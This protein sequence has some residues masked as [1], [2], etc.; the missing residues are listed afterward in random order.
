M[1]KSKDIIEAILRD[2]TSQKARPQKAL[3]PTFILVEERTMEDFLDFAFRFSEQLKY[4]NLTDTAEGTWQVFFSMFSTKEKI[5]KLIQDWG[6]TQEMEP[7]QA[8]FLSFLKLFEHLKNDINQITQ[9]H[10]DFFYKELLA[11]TVNEPIPDKVHL[12]FEPAKNSS[13]PKIEKDTPLNAGKDHSGN[14]RVYLTSR[15]LIVSHAS[16]ENIKTLFIDKN[17]NGE[18]WSAPYANS[19]DGQGTAFTDNKK[20]PPFGMSQKGLADANRNMVSAT[21]GFAIASPMLL[22]SEGTRNIKIDIA[23]QSRLPLLINQNLSNGFTILLSTHKG[24]VAPTTFQINLETESAIPALNQNAFNKITIQATL[25]P[26]MPAVSK[27]DD[28]LLKEGFSSD[29]PLVKILYDSAILPYDMLSK[30]VISTIDINT[31]VSGLKNVV[32]QNDTGVLDPGKPFNPF[33]SNPSPGSS[34]YIGHQEF[35]HKK[36]ENLQL[37]IDWHEVPQENLGTWYNEY[38]E[39]TPPPMSS[40]IFKADL[41]LLHNRNWHLKLGD[42]IHLFNVNAKEIRKIKITSSEFKNAL[43]LSGISYSASLHEDEP[44]TYSHLSS[45]GFLKLVLT[46]PAGSGSIFEAFGHKEYIG[47][48]TQAAID[49]ALG[50]EASFPNKPYTPQIKELSI[51][52]TASERITLKNENSPSSFFHIEPFGFAAIK[53]ASTQYLLPQFTHQGYLFMGVKNLTPPQN[54]SLLFQ[55]LEGSADPSK[56]LTPKSIKWFYLSNNQWVELHDLDVLFDSTQGLQTSG[57]IELSVGSKATDQN[58]VMPPNLFWLRASV[59]DHTEGANYLIDILPNAVTARFEIKPKTDNT[60]HYSQPLPKNTIKKLL[61]KDAAIKSISQPYPSFNGR[62]RELDSSLYTRVSERL[63]HKNRAS[64]I[65]DYE[66]LILHEFPEMHKIKC[67]SH[68]SHNAYYAPGNVT[69]IPIQDITHQNSI[70]PLEPKTSSLNLN[71]ISNFLKRY[72]SPFVEVNIENPRYEKLI[73]HFKVAFF[74]DY[75]AGYYGHLLNDEIKKYLSPWAFEQGEDIVFGGKIYRSDLLYFIE[76]RPYVD[77]VNSFKLY[78][79]NRE[80]L[81]GGI[82]DM[83]IETDFI[84]RALNPPG[85]NEMSIG[86]DFII[87]EDVEIAHS[88]SPKSI[89]TSVEDHYISVIDAHEDTCRAVEYEGIGFMTVGMDFIVG[90]YPYALGNVN[91]VPVARRLPES[92]TLLDDLIVTANNNLYNP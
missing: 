38:A 62:P 47:K 44:E 27:Y 46:L 72:I 92:E 30:E 61:V 49:K 6:K 37:Q 89:L 65:W 22:L 10:L 13:Q 69:I 79:L 36:L 91:I 90:K 17:H 85:I 24:W 75:D 19:M 28:E 23:L 5:R 66:H 51:D 73:A 34:F 87:G 9:R 4:Y 58:T 11:F 3:N 45:S 1:N 56:T 40:L 52:Y 84:V 77:Y 42:N 35:L 29:W 32:V 83:A 50:L 68:T 86:D 80:S 14:S 7:H 39:G 70:N 63:R 33:G 31:S 12:I 20:W 18:I 2:G 64:G 60:A 54:I 16:I 67:L 88:S 43:A 8:L 78:H 74:P 21:I 26:D 55:Q 48:Y 41:H 71:K 81:Q 25:S 57:I 53:P 59:S 15:E 82:G 76:N